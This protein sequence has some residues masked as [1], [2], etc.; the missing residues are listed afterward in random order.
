MREIKRIIVHCSFTKAS[1]DFT[2]D[3]IRRWHV[4]DNGWSDI[5]YHAVICRDGTT[6]DGRPE[7]IAGAHARGY[8]AD[9]IGV[10]LVGGKGFDGSEAFNFTFNQLDEL[11][12]YIQR[13]C[14]QYGITEVVG[15]NQVSSKACPCFDV[16]EF[17]KGII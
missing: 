12:S 1:Q 13:K 10:C 5:G 16:E 17:V 7:E 15:H 3:D 8:N 6:Q 14:Q 11:R 9:S 4:E 2:A